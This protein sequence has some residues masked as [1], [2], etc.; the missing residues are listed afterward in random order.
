M[1]RTK[2]ILTVAYAFVLLSIGAGFKEWKAER[3][4]AGSLAAATRRREFLQTSLTKTKGQLIE[5]EET[6]MLPA[7]KM[8][9]LEML[10][11]LAQLKKEGLSFNIQ[12]LAGEEWVRR[13]RLSP[14]FVQLFG[15]TSAEEIE[16]NQALA[17]A[18]RQV[19]G[20]T[21]A[22]GKSR[23]E[24]NGQKIVVE[25]AAFP[26]A[27]GKIY[28]QLFDTFATALGPDRRAIFDQFMGNEQVGAEYG[29]FGLEEETITISRATGPNGSVVYNF[30]AV[31]RGAST[32]TGH[33][34][35]D[36]KASLV[37]MYPEAALFLPAGY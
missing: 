13:R 1:S 35:F 11:T 26:E 7:K 10:Q 20:L 6:V 24:D 32:S 2:I 34:T 14:G 22:M 33:G 31:D 5:L 9:N 4:A 18:G 16:L 23:Q 29:G 21:L 8:S 27:G 30:Q 28:D 15:L 25:I 36:D 19:D 12:V 37:A 17:D 3:A